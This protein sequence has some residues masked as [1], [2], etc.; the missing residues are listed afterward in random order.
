MSV[1]AKPAR[2]QIPVRIE[3][4]CSSCRASPKLALFPIAAHRA[5]HLVV[6]FFWRFDRVFIWIP[7]HLAS[8]LDGHER[9]MAD[10]VGAQR[11]LNRRD[12]RR[13][14]AHTIHE[15]FVITVRSEEHTSELQSL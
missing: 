13:A 1:P 14:F 15:R 5:V 10:G 9:E 6:Q 3:L 7:N 4:E 12:G 2:E 11:V 8:G